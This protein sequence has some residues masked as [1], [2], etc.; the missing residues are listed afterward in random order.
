MG[1][2][3]DIYSQ[4]DYVLPSKTDRLQDARNLSNDMRQIGMDLNNTYDRLGLEEY[5][6][7]G[8]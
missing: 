4:R 5:C 3:L 8:K 7:H 6:R 2:V 1:S